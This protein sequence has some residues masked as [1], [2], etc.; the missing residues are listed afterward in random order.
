[1]MINEYTRDYRYT[2][3]FQTLFTSFHVPTNFWCVDK[4]KFI[5]KCKLINVQY[6]LNLAYTS[7]D[8]SIYD[9]ARDFV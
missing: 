2:I 4:C 9:F 7:P 8:I 3:N 5:C 1:M 6:C